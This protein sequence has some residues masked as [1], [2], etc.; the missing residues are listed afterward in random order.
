MTDKIKLKPCPFC[1]ATTLSIDHERV[2][3]EMSLVWV[4]CLGC[5]AQ[6]PLVYD[7]ETAKF[8][9]NSR[10]ERQDEKVDE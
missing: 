3:D 8:L 10:H 1:G 6:G 5:T 2:N 7:D 4:S 9:W